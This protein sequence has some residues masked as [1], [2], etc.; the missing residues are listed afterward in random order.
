[1]ILSISINKNWL[2][3]A[4]IQ[5]G[6]AMFFAFFGAVYEL[7]SHGVYSYY[8]IYA[9]F[10]P[11]LLGALPYGL[12]S[13]KNRVRFR[14]PAVICWNAGITTITLGCE[15]KGVLDIY[16]TGNRLILA[17]PAAGILLM[18]IAVILFITIKPSTKG[19]NEDAA[20]IG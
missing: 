15:F 17:Y 20:V 6:N 2:K 16:G 14:K 4:L 19:D 8:M 10:I 9:F 3:H 1:M 11:L 18:I 12:I 13:Y 5:L 7:F